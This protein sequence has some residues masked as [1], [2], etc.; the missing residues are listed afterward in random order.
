MDQGAADARLAQHFR[1]PL[2]GV[3]LANCPQ[4][5]HHAL[6]GELDGEIRRIELNQPHADLRARLRHLLG[7]GKT[8]V[9]AHEPP[10]PDQRGNRDIERAAALCAQFLCP[11]QQREQAR[12]DPHGPFGGVGV[13]VG[14]F[15][16]GAEEAE[17]RFELFDLS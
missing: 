11:L 16:A 1:R 6:P 10:A 12:R 5:Q 2:D 17:L 4:V 3:A 14:D 7:T 13:E 9:S 8:P 15:A